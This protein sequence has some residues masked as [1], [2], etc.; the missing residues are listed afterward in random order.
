MMKSSLVEKDRKT[1]YLGGRELL[2]LM[3]KVSE[4]EGKETTNRLFM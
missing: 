2:T 1:I 3:D 4:P